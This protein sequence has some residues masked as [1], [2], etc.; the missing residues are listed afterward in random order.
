MKRFV[1]GNGVACGARVL[2]AALV[3]LVLTSAMP[4]PANAWWFFH[5]RKPSAQKIEKKVRQLAAMPVGLVPGHPPALYWKPDGKPKATVLCL[6]ELGFYG[7]VFDDL[8]KRLASQGMAVYAID[9]RGFG[10]WSSI[11]GKDTQM[12]MKMIVQDIK[13]S[14]E[15]IRKL[16]PGTPLFLL[17]EAMGG[18]LVLKV[19][20]DYPTLANGVIT[21]APSGDHY[22]TTKNYSAVA[23]NII[24][25]GPGEGCDYGEQLMESAT[26]R[27]D[28]RQAF[29]Q[30]PKVRMDLAPR[31][32]M[33]CQFFMYKTK[34]MAKQ[35]KNTPVLVVHGEKDGES[36]ESGSAD[37]YNALKT[38]DK[39]YLKLPD[40]DHYTYEDVNVS[41]KA[42]DSTLAWIEKHLPSL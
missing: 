15:V 32:L 27:A 7:G 13:D 16:H 8:G 9:E 37:I 5:K 19:A 23:A 10:G 18:S 24:K 3:A 35:I 17:G 2:S 11:P 14:A 33:A 39:E 38:K 1:S 21:A 20:A 34:G 6:H 28:L 31:E 25:A 42:F 30:D 12:D 40:G 29:L 26:P 36:K 22:N 4:T 41:S